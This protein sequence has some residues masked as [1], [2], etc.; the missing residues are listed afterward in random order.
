MRKV[1]GVR[2]Q[3]R[4]ITIIGIW[5]R[6]AAKDPRIAG[7]IAVSCPGISWSHWALGPR[8]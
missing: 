2:Y 4:I 6:Q 3:N 7:V 5:L 8:A 1:S